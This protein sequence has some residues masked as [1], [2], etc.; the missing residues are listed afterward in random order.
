M[1]TTAFSSAIRA[2]YSF[3]GE[4]ILLGAAKLNNETIKECFIRLPLS[5]MNR[6]GLIAGATGTGK[7]KSL[8]LLAEQLSHFGVPSLVMDIKGDLSGIAAQGE[9]NAKIEER[10]AAIGLPFIPGKSPVEF[11]SLSKEPGA[12]LRATVTEFGPVL[13]SKL[14]D[15]N[16]TQQGVITVIF[17]FCDDHELP[18]LDLEDL[19][20]VIHY[21]TTDGKADFEKEYGN[22][23]STTTGTIVRKIIELEQQGAAEFFGEPSIDVSDLL[24]T[25]KEGHGIVHILRLTDLQDRPKLFS[26]CVLQMLAEIYATFPEAGDLKKP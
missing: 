17:K 25:D 5:T 7:T 10:Y 9:S 13:F 22:I 20:K 23:V 26:T 15:L 8:Q 3:E 2:G 24:R 4:S 18:L 19:K 14:L 21:I 12:K 11:L 6:H 1:D 16:E